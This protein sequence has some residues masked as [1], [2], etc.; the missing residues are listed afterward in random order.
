[1]VLIANLEMK[2]CVFCY[3]IFSACSIDVGTYQYAGL[4][5]FATHTSN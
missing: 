2:T 5:R 3:W 1:V 4:D